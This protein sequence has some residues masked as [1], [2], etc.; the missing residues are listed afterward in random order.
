MF[1]SWIMRRVGHYHTEDGKCVHNYG[2]KKFKGRNKLEDLDMDRR[3]L[4]KYTSK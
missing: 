3:I 4:L 1:K 2:Q